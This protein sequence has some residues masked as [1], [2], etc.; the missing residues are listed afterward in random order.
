MMGTEWA[1]PP[2]VD[3]RG[4]EYLEMMRV[5]VA[6]EAGMFWSGGVFIEDVNYVWAHET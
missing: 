1:A 2:L 6:K 4:F 5:T 3:I